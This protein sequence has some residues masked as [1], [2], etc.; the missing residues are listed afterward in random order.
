MRHRRVLRAAGPCILCAVLILPCLGLSGCGARRPKTWKVGILSAPASFLIIADGFKAR[1]T[2]LGYE[3]GRTI[4][5]DVQGVA[6]EASEMERVVRDFVANRVDL[7]L[8]LTTGP[9]LA[10]KTGT[11]GTR[12]PVVFAFAGVED[13]DL[14]QSIQ[15]PGG[16]LT[17]VRFP[18]PEQIAK[19][20]EYLLAIAPRVRRVWV[21]YQKGY[22]NCEPALHSL[23]TLAASRGVT[24]V[25]VPVAA[26]EELEAD[27]AA[28][29]KAADP[30]VD[31]IILMPDPLNHSTAGWALLNAWGAEM[32]IPI[33][34]SF[35]YTV[36]QGAL[37]GNSNDLSGVGAMAATLADRIFRGAFAGTLPVLTPE[38]DLVI[39][40]GVA[41]RLG[42]TIPRDLL[43]MAVE[44]IR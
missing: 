37:F 13:N 26:L 5:Y 40:Q 18:G 25:E 3:E 19:R 17:G 34:G 44:V 35:R 23:R 16:N 15:Q 21:G 14:V 9:S 8:S 39:N 42:L 20:L 2:E 31:A 27:L 32:H 6:P 43:S 33:A 12:I 29:R 38:D 1:M 10:A 30:G 22:P 36:E 7:V 24:L 28:R 4:S 41:E 11:R